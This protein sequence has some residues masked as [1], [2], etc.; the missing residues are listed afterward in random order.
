MPPAEPLKVL[1]FFPHFQRS[2]I[3]WKMVLILEI[4]VKVL[5][6]PCI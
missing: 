4:G 2:G 3:C 5:E 1:A 6:R